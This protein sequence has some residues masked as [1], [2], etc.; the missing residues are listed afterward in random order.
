M[1]LYQ[2]A[3]QVLEDT[4][5][6]RVLSEFGEFALEGSYV[7]RTMVDRDID[8]HV[9][10][11]DGLKLSY[12]TRAEVMARLM[13]VPNLRGI[14]MA[15]I[16]HFPSG[17]TH[18]I[19][20]IWYGLG[21]ISNDTSERWNIDIWV[22]TPDSATEADPK[23]IKRLCNLT[24]NER[25]TIVAIKQAALDAGQK[26]KGVTSV[27]IYRAVLDRGA[28]SYDEFLALNDSL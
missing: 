22:I 7:Y 27:E 21:I 11:K 14:Q 28:S 2:E 4:P 13:D 15:D 1:D 23:L 26:E 9:V 24:D 12:E 3:A 18:Q 6:E 8:C 5:L 20:G 10:L 19:D 16:H 25:E 17:S